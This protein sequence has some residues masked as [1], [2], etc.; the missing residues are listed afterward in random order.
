[1]ASRKLWGGRFQGKQDPVALAFT[2]SFS[3]DQQ[4]WEEDIDIL[5]AH[6]TMLVEKQIVQKEVGKKILTTLQSI[7]QE[8]N[9][10]KLVLTSEH[11]D[12]HSF[13]EEELT[14]RIGEE[15]SLIR[16]GR[17]RND[18]VVTDLRLYL[19]R[20][21]SEILEL[22]HQYLEALIDLGERFQDVVIPGYTHFRRAQPIL[23]SFYCLAHFAGGMR[24][25]QALEFAHQWDDVSTLG[26][27]AVSG[28]SWPIEPKISSK[29]LGFSETFFN[30]LD[31]V[32]ERDFLLAFYFACNLILTH[33]SRLSEDLIL[34]SSEGLAYV[35]LP[36]DLCTGSSLMPQKKNPDP[37]EL[38]RG[39]TGRMF[40]HLSSL[41][42][43]LKGLPMGY[44]RDLQE[45]K[46]PL[47]DAIKTI[48]ESLYMMT[49][50]LEGLSLSKEAL[51]KV[52]VDDFS[53]A[54][55]L[56]DELVKSGYSFG[57][58]HA[59]AG[60]LVR[61]CDEKG[62]FLKDLTAEEIK[63]MIPKAD[64]KILKFLSIPESAKRRESP[65]GTGEKAVSKALIEAKAWLKE[66]APKTR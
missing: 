21:L 37:L 23:F 15:A 22:H 33:F 19:K 57:E 36:D 3:F 40:G 17:S 6:V 1:M 62:K 47:F 30:A 43:L 28:T 27:G 10:S 49:R 38:L 2:E 4:M 65:G 39:K 53:L 55:D 52:W 48:K 35:D 58:A 41:F 59:Y 32:S 29:L 25:R 50:I 45:D 26:A 51:A 61:H 63:K 60:K 54:T 5:K 34:W 20:E 46:E 8:I 44:N 14:K 12:I 18:T 7:H 66:K 24:E 64:G 13:I 56:A 9:E 16:I 42:M 11:E 31:A